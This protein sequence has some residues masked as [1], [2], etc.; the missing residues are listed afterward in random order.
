MTLQ[1]QWYPTAKH[2]GDSG[3][4]RRTIMAIFGNTAVHRIHDISIN[5]CVLIKESFHCPLHRD[6]GFNSQ[7]S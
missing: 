5:N 7:L 3:G 4:G 1:L 2:L 6:N